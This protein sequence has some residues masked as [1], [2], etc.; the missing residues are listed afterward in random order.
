MEVPLS[1]DGDPHHDL[2]C[3]VGAV[4]LSWAV[5][6]SALGMAIALIDDT[7]G[8]PKGHREL[9][10]TALTKKLDYLRIALRDVPSL[11]PLNERGRALIDGFRSLKGRRDE[12]THGLAR[13]VFEKQF[14]SVRFVVEGRKQTPTLTFLSA[15]DVIS[16][17]PEIMRL[18]DDAMSFATLVGQIDP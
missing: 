4:T 7:F 18:T 16:L 13:Q 15:Q 12:I 5:A 3:A 6:E 17:L 14:V 1:H 10:R 9:P 8:S 11:E 2:A